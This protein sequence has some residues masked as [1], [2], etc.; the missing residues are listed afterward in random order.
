MNNLRNVDLNLLVIFEAIFSTGN[1]SQAAKQL[2]ISQPTVSNS[3]TRLRESLDDQLFVRAKHGVTP[4]PKATQIIGAVRE[5]L[6]IIQVGITGGESF[7]PA[8]TKRTFRL[9]VAEPMEQVIMPPLI[10]GLPEGSSISFDYFSP[11]SQNIE[12]S[13]ITG[14]TELAIFLLPPKTPDLRTKVLCPLDVVGIVRQGHPR[15]GK[16]SSITKKQ[17]IK[18]SHVTLNLQP[19]KITNSEKVSVL[20]TPSRSTVCRVSNA[21]AVARIVGATDLFGVIPGLFAEYAAKPLGLKIFKLPMEMNTQKMFM[22]WHVR[23]ST[24]NAHIWLRN[25][26]QSLVEAVAGPQPE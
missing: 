8:L 4:T 13:L 11:L 7:D 25:R 9:V 20:Q 26:I 17:F 19:G 2:G 24:D 1:V 22:I 23:H 15:L 10:N 6:Q 3:L 18:E 16:L 14:T 5:A 12:E 21:G